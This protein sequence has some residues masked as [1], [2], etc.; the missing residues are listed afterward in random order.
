MGATPKLAVAWPGRPP[1]IC[2]MSSAASCLRVLSQ[3]SLPQHATVM[4]ITN[5]SSVL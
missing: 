4:M 3:S 1:V 5:G 2:I